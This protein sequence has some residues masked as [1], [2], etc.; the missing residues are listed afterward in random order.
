MIKNELLKLGME[1][2]EIDNHESDLYIKVNKIS[3]GWVKKYKFSQNVKMFRDNID[4]ELWY[5]IPFG[6]MNIS[7]TEGYLIYKI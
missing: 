2:N 6:Y 4:N 1:E 7:D 3:K 5:N